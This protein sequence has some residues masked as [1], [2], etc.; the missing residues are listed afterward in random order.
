MTATKSTQ[1]Q[2][3]RSDR[4]PPAVPEKDNVYRSQSDLGP[5]ILQTKFTTKLPPSI[6][7]S[8]RKNRL[9]AIWS[10]LKSK[11]LKN[12]YMILSQDPASG[13]PPP[14]FPISCDEKF[15][16]NLYARLNLLMST[17]ANKFLM[18]E[19]D[20][21]RLTASTAAKYIRHW[22]NLGR[23]HF[24]EFQCSQPFQAFIIWECRHM[25]EFHGTYDT[26][27]RSVVLDIWRKNATSMSVLTHCNGDSAIQKHLHD[28]WKVLEILGGTW[29]D[30]D[31]LSELHTSFHTMVAEA[32]RRNDMNGVTHVWNP[33]GIPQTP[34]QLALMTPDLSMQTFGN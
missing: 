15:Q 23:P 25:L 16:S 4:T 3:L 5:A 22:I 2:S 32:K 21:S 13:L 8:G 14:K 26:R 30:F 17:V 29:A 9:S 18:T 27:I 1:S 7:K 12:V 24:A 31:T 34:R 28:S 33:P 19:Y 11:T 10:D 6:T 20:Q